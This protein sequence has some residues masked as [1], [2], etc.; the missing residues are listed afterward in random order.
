MPSTSDAA[1]SR[2]TLQ[3]VEPINEL[4]CMPTRNFQ[5]GSFDGIESLDSLGMRK[6]ARVRKTGCMRCPA[7]CGSRCEVDQGKYAGA[8]ARPEFETIALL[9]PNCGVSDFAAVVRAAQLCDELGIDTMSA[10]HAVALT[11]ELTE[12]GLISVAD[13]HG[14]EVRFGD[15]DG[16]IAG[17]ALIGERQGIGDEL[18]EGMYQVR[19]DHPEW[20][21]YILAVKGMPFAGY[22]PRGFHGNA[23]TYGTSSRGACHNTG[24]WTIRA[25]LQDGGMDR[26]ALSGKGPLVK[27][28]QDARAYLDSTG[29]C[30]V[31]REAYGLTEEPHGDALEAVTGHAFTPRL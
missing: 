19:R 21:R 30:S 24:G 14:V 23:L 22:D 16:L 10:G 1:P 9:G 28:I 5:T 27:S 4:G 25:E 31:V 2:G 18:A 26:Y 20:S 11:M 12:R 17:I 15:P 3:Y 6:S 13:T 8:R 29:L 7:A